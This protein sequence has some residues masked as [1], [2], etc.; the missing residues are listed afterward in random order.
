MQTSLTRGV[1]KVRRNADFVAMASTQIAHGRQ[2]LST[3][4]GQPVGS[5]QQTA[6]PLR[7]LGI[8][9]GHNAAHAQRATLMAKDAS[10]V[11]QRGGSVVDQVVQTMQGISDASRKIVDIT[12]VIDGIAF[13]TNI[14]ALK[15]AVEAARAGEQGRRFS[16]VAAE[17]ISIAHRS[18]GATREIKSL[19]ASSAEQ[20]D[21]GSSLV[22]QTCETMHE[23]M[24]AIE[25]V[26]AIVSDISRASAEPDSGVS[27]VGK[28]IKH[29]E[30]TTNQKR[31]AVGA[32]HGGG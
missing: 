32:I 3:R 28:A 22:T 19:I 8:T 30:T 9:V 4:T 12:S 16:V 1:A 14:L 21:L 13:Q 10:G 2:D 27:Q 5:L 6:E 18:T 20:V 29:M 26:N 7:E 25:R 24:A 15:A 11:A 23:I 17:V 31:R